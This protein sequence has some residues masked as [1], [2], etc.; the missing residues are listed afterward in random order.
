MPHSDETKWNSRYRSEK[1]G[2]LSRQPHA[3]LTSY[4][5]SLPET[6]L[7]LDIACGLAASSLSLAARHWRV[8][9]L[10]IAEAALRLVQEKARKTDIP[11]SLAVIDLTSPWL[12]DSYFDAI[13]NFY[14]LSRSLWD[15]YKKSLKPGGWLFVETFVWQPGI[16]V[17][18][19]YYLHPGELRQAFSDWEI[20]HYKELQ[21]PHASDAKRQVAQFVARKPG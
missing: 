15:V 6:G 18:R 3:L 4:T 14:F 13:L 11:V 9:G 5:D 20:M 16:D 19:E 10:D 21:R 8:I 7:V 2:Y 17:D 12:P 1:S